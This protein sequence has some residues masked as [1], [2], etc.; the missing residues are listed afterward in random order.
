MGGMAKRLGKMRGVGAGEA[1]FRLGSGETVVARVSRRTEGGVVTLLAEV[2]LADAASGTRAEPLPLTHPTT[3]DIAAVGS[4]DV[5]LGALLTTL[6]QEAADRAA[7]F[8]EGR[9]Q[10]EALPE[11]ARDPGNGETGGE[12]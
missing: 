12:R 4:G 5:D 2:T 7:H 8:L 9:R 11:V 1:A 3:L 6:Q 10:L